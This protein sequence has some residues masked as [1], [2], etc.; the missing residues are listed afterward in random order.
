M[1]LLDLMLLALIV[2]LAAWRPLATISLGSHATPWQASCMSSKNLPKCRKS[3][4]WGSKNA[5]ED[6][7][8]QGKLMKS[9]QLPM[10]A[11]LAAT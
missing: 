5:K 8:E 10:M 11:T 1:L 7:Q 6:Q 2:P 4:G 3:D 9:Q